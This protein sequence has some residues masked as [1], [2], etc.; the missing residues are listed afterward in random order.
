[1]KYQ[2]KLSNIFLIIQYVGRK[3][4]YRLGIRTANIPKINCLFSSL[5]KGYQCGW[6][7]N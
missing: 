4:S 3:I 5:L 2:I 1:M 7:S 6:H